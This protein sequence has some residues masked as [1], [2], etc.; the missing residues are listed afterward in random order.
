MIRPVPFQGHF[1][2]GEH[3]CVQGEEEGDGLPRSTRGRRLRPPSQRLDSGSSDDEGPP[4]P[5]VNL[6]R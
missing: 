6:P 1:V 4:S 5:S 2:D 3:V